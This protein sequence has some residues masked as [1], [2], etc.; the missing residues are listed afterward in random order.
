MVRLSGENPLTS[1]VMAVP[2]LT[3]AGMWSETETPANARLTEGISRQTSEK[4][5]MT[6]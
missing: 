5:V 6:K 1:S 3:T 4:A 2:P